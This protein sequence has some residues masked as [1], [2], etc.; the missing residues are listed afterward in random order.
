MDSLASPFRES[1]DLLLACATDLP[2]VNPVERWQRVGP[3]TPHDRALAR[4][5]SAR[6]DKAWE[7]R[8][9]GDERN[10]ADS[11]SMK[12]SRQLVGVRDWGL[13]GESGTDQGYGFFFL[14]RRQLRN[15][16]GQ[17]RWKILRNGLIGR[18]LEH[19]LAGRVR[20]NRRVVESSCQL[21]IP[22][23]HDLCVGMRQVDCGNS[24]GCDE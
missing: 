12:A 4:S 14:D 15:G 2:S 23:D 3:S 20:A 7:G 13:A 24:I 9:G 11:E 5:C 17:R 10:A 21:I 6:D 8:D 1:K 18:Q 16:C 19:G 22:D